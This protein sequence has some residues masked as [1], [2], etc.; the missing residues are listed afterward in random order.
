M[1]GI[2]DKM[3]DAITR[4][5]KSAFTANKNNRWKYKLMLI[6]MLRVNTF[7]LLKINKNTLTE[8]TGELIIYFLKTHKEF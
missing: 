4:V 3:F 7:Y 2:L 1:F 5:M 8:N 6:K